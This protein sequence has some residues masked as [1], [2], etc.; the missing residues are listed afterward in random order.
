[1][2]PLELERLAARCVPGVGPVEIR[3]LNQGLVNG[4]YRVERGGV[5]YALRVAAAQAGGDSGLDRAWEAR[6]LQ[7]AAA[8]GLAPAVEYCDTQRGILL[9]RWIDGRCWSA[10]EVRTG[11]NLGAIAALLRR[12]HALP[13]PDL[14][15]RMS[16]RGW[17]D[18]YHS[19]L[20]RSAV[21]R[22]AD[23]EALRAAAGARLDRLGTLPA[24]RAVVCHSDLHIGNVLDC[25][26]ALILLD[27]E[28]AHAS[29]PWW[30][31]AGW[32]AN[33][34]LEDKH[35]LELLSHY[36]GRAPTPADSARLDALCWL[37]DYTCVL[38]SELYLRPP[39]G[40]ARAPH[41][42]ARGEGQIDGVEARARLLEAR[43]R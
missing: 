4:T 21:G 27:W 2:Q 1:M 41:D 28:Y 19:A 34:D 8:A 6:V 36:T 40:D 7:S 35:R 31:L 15:R 13:L 43:L 38:W 9:S 5:A 32:S 22:T 33:N 25:G 14:P 18:Y 3:Q 37:Y 12:V 11:P 39:A 17:I 20:A 16:L 42:A 26:Q 30:D 29:D 10:A 24:E 23:D